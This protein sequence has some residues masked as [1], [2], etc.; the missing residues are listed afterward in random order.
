M[1]S[2]PSPKKIERI[3]IAIV[4]FVLFSLEITALGMMSNY[5]FSSPTT[6]NV[7]IYIM[8]ILC[9]VVLLIF[10]LNAWENS[11]ESEDRK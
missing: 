10:F 8:L 3:I 6:K 11:F 5:V 1:K 9:G 4:C 2:G 7:T